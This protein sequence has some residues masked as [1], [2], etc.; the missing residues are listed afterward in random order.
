MESFEEER[1]RHLE[2]MVLLLADRSDA[3][4]VLDLVCVRLELSPHLLDPAQVWL[5]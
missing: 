5:V 1:K 3:V 2:I 4:E